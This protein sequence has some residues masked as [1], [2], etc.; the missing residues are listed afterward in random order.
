MLRGSWEPFIIWP[1]EPHR[2]TECSLTCVQRMMDCLCVR[3]WLLNMPAFGCI[4][5]RIA[6]A[7]L[8]MLGVS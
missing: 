5:R 7:I 8:H 4:H 2:G 1:G 3:C 6:D